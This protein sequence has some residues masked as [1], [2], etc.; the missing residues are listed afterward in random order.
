MEEVSSL[1]HTA[2]ISVAEPNLPEPPGPAA[3]PS[4]P[5]H[6]GRVRWTICT[7]LFVATSINYVVLG[8]LAP[9]LQCTIGWTDLQYSYIISGFQFAYALGLL[10][11]GR[12]VRDAAAEASP[13]PRRVPGKRLR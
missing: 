9:V 10:L 11:A 5:S 3:S 13:C 8:I 7:M 4:Q 1:V 12:M 2:P 6:M